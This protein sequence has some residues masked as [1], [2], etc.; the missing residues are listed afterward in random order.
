GDAP[1]RSRRP[2]RCA[3]EESGGAARLKRPP[4]SGLVLRA[5]RRRILIERIEIRQRRGFAVAEL[6]GAM[7]ARQAAQLGIEV[8]GVALQ[9]VERVDVEGAQIDAVEAVARPIE[10][11]KVVVAED[12]A[13]GIGIAVDAQADGIA[14]IGRPENRQ[15][16]IR[17]V[18]YAP[19][20]KRLA[21]IAALP[22]EAGT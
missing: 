17:A 10:G 4:R 15:H 19:A 3:A 1:R 8:D 18:G 16:E 6:R 9:L 21:E 12:E 13:P 7:L 20:E 14:R 2:G 5:G 22:L 11:L